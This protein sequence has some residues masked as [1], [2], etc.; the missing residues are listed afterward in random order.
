MFVK[1]ILTGTKYKCSSSRRKDCHFAAVNVTYFLWLDICIHSCTRLC[2]DVPLSAQWSQHHDS[3]VSTF[4]T[5]HRTVGCCCLV[6]FG[7][8]FPSAFS[9]YAYASLSVMACRR[10]STKLCHSRDTGEW[11]WFQNQNSVMT[12]VSVLWVTPITPH[13][14]LQRSTKRK[15]KAFGLFA[16]HLHPNPNWLFLKCQEA[17]III[18]YLG[19]QI[20][21]FF[22]PF[23]FCWICIWLLCRTALTWE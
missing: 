16:Y 9:P 4:E 2:V 17:H 8:M 10:P 13:P 3:L 6:V 19:L 14:T 20:V 12:G 5:T 21:F 11:S 18:Y 23:T 7:T 15:I 22:F 1:H